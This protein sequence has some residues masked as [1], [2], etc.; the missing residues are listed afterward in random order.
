MASRLRDQRYPKPTPPSKYNEGWNDKSATT[1]ESNA[2]AALAALGYHGVKA[3][4][5]KRLRS[6]DPHEI[7]IEVMAEVRAYFQ[8]AYKVS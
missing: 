3:D 7:E 6:P 4:D 8:I 1:N 5:L 2:L